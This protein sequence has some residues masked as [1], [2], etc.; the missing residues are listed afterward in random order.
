MQ[1]LYK[2][3]RDGWASNL[4]FTSSRNPEQEVTDEF[5]LKVNK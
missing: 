2:V 5:S 1:H 4:T 3:G